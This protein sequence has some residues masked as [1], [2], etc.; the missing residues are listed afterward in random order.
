[1]VYCYP[2]VRMNTYYPLAKRFAATWQQ[3][4]PSIDYDLHVV[5][6]GG[7]PQ[8]ID[9]QVFNGLPAQFHTHDNIGWDIGAF[10]WS[11]EAIPCDLMVCLGAPVH[12][13]RAG[14]LEKMADS[15][16]ENGPG[17]YGCTAYGGPVL[18][19]RTTSFW[20]HP[21]LLQSYPYSIGN[22]RAMRY[23]FEHGQH[24]FT[25]HTMSAG[26]PCVMVT[27]RGVFPFEQWHENAPT[28][29]EILVRDQHVH[30]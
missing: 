30:A 12:F 8:P 17:L 25:R 21:Q 15:Y 6:N 19:V 2:L 26:F 7:Q 23:D 27:W 3:F 14:W 10:Q 29:E 20:M 18:H 9:L 28:A 1:M 22:T 13:W 5:C 16:I 24:S 11:A 4:P